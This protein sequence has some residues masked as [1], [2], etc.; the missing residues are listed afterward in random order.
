MLPVPVDWH[1]DAELDEKG[2]ETGWTILSQDDV[3]ALGGYLLEVRN[4]IA[5]ANKCLEVR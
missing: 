2:Q 1:G 5:S 3:A 4:W